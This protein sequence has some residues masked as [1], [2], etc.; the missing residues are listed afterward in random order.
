[1][2][3][4]IVLINLLV[5]MISFPQSRWV[6]AAHPLVLLFAVPS[7]RKLVAMRLRLAFE[8]L[9]EPRTVLPVPKPPVTYELNDERR[10]P[11]GGM[12]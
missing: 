6:R 12:H 5:R 11:I 9:E 1:M 3:L 7:L 2:V 8:G 10:G 4:A